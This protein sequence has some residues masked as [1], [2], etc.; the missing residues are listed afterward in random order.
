MSNEIKAR[1]RGI[2]ESYWGSVRQDLFGTPVQLRELVRRRPDALLAPLF[3][4]SVDEGDTPQW[5]LLAEPRVCWPQEPAGQIR[6]WTYDRGGERSQ[7]VVVE[8]FKDLITETKSMVTVDIR[9]IECLVFSKTDLHG[10]ATLD[11]M[12]KHACPDW[13]KDV[14]HENLR[15]LLAKAPPAYTEG[16]LSQVDWDGRLTLI[17]YD[18]SHHFAAARY[19]AG[20]LDVSV[21]MTMELSTRSINAQALDALEN[22]YDAFVLLDQPAFNQALTEAFQAT[23]VPHGRKELRLGRALG[24]RTHQLI[25]LPRE[26][27]RAMRSASVLH[28]AGALTLPWLLRAQQ[29]QAHDY[30][31]IREQL[32]S[33]DL[34][35]HETEVGPRP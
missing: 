25:L 9:D 10:F 33:L 15:A 23:Q 29:L 8:H 30:I 7:K 34:G 13:I 26:S 22:S 11:D 3:K 21:P 5:E 14:S 20:Q 1:Q 17:A 28:D 35:D 27:V 31:S 4:Q 24:D 19:L 32:K 6:M 2:V 18:G 12:A 16:R